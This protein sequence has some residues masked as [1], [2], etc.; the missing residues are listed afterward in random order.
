MKYAK[1]WYQGNVA[2]LIFRD[3]D[4]SSQRISEFLRAMGDEYL[5]REFFKKSHFLAHRIKGRNHNRHNR[6][7]NPDLFSVQCMVIS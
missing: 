1:M 7:A 3:I 4:L 5:Q 6:Y 2:R